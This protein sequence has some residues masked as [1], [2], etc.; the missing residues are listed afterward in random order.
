MRQL[1]FAAP[2]SRDGKRPS[3]PIFFCAAIDMAVPPSETM[4]L[5]CCT[6]QSWGIF[7]V[8][9]KDPISFYHHK[10]FRECMSRA[11]SQE[12]TAGLLW[13]RQVCWRPPGFRFCGARAKL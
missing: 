2:S 5:R 1:Q 13:G 11:V 8:A 9:A 7:L 10:N 12:L 4:I 3:I 6:Q